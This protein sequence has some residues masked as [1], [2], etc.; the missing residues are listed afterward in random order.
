MSIDGGDSIVKTIG[1]TERV[2]VHKTKINVIE[3]AAMISTAHVT[4]N[5]LDT[6]GITS[7]FMLHSH[8]Q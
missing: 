7:R 4:R 2:N 3:R 8:C 1:S 5:M 6:K